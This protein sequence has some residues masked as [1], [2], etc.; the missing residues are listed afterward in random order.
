MRMHPCLARNLLRVV[1]VSRVDHAS[2]HG[3][4]LL[5]ESLSY[6][7]RVASAANVAVENG[8]LSMKH[9]KPSRLVCLAIGL[10]V[11][12][13][14]SALAGEI[15]QLPQKRLMAVA[16]DSLTVAGATQVP[17][18]TNYTVAQASGANVTITAVLKPPVPADKLPAGSVTWTNGNAGTS[19][20]ERLVSRDNPAD[21]TVTATCGAV[22]KSVRVVVRRACGANAVTAPTPNP[23]VNNNAGGND[24]RPTR[25]R[26]T[27]HVCSDAGTDVWTVRVDSLECL[28]Q[29]NIRPWP[30]RPNEMVVPNTANA[31]A[32]GNIN[33]TPGSNNRWSASVADMADYDQA[34][35][36]AGPHWHSTPASSA[37]EHFHWDTNWMVTSIGPAGGDWARTEQDLENLQVSA[38]TNLTEAEA[39][40]ALDPLVRARDLTFWNAAVARWN[41][42]PDTPGGGGGGYAAGVTVLNGLIGAVEAYRTANGW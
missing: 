19:Q 29:I 12:G 10:L 8:G 1:M 6:R 13:A 2:R 21:V 14:A 7:I 27:W 40:A 42:I 18:T 3:R 32:G 23:T 36:G 16:L 28:G 5:P 9:G 41:A 33:N 30:S 34:G 24:C 22:S 11:L 26:L 15:I 4:A 25:S 35:G 39:R 31:V 37:H 38:L 17:G 20:L